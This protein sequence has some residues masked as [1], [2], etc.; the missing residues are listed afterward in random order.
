MEQIP[1]LKGENPE[2][3]FRRMWTHHILHRNDTIYQLW[4]II[5]QARVIVRCLIYFYLFL[6]VVLNKMCDFHRSRWI[7]SCIF[8]CLK[9]WCCLER[10]FGDRLAFWGPYLCR[11][12]SSKP[13]YERPPFFHMMWM[14]LSQS[15]YP[16][17]MVVPPTYVHHL[18]AWNIKWNKESK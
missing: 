10:N 2:F 12:C 16:R 18:I 5:T 4:P 11:P 9:K 15:I 8:N 14:P 1:A 6:W 7:F 13:L 17:S 3:H